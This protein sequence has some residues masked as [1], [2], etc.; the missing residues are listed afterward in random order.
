MI[1]LILLLYVCLLVGISIFSKKLIK[2]D[3]DYLLAGRS[4]P[5]SIS[6]FALFATWFGSE[7]ILGASQEFV[8]EDSLML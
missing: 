5:F 6:M 8:K 4:L 7:T 1:Y 2:S 3:K